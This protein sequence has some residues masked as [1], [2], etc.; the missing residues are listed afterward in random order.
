MSTTISNI[1]NFEFDK[2]L[3]PELLE[4]TYA[5]EGTEPTLILG[6]T[7]NWK[8]C[9]NPSDKTSIVEIVPPY[10]KKPS[11]IQPMIID[12]VDSNMKPVLIEF[13]DGS[14][15]IALKLFPNPDSLTISSSKIVNRYNTMTRW[16]EEHWGDDLDTINFSGSTYSFNAEY[17]ANVRTGL[18]SVFRNYS[19]SY[20]F[21]KELVSLYRTNG[22]LYQEPNGYAMT[23]SPTTEKELFEYS[24]TNRFLLQNPSFQNRH[25]RHGM[26]RERL[27]IRITFDYVTFIGYFESFDITEDTTSPFRLLYS[28]V[29]KAEKT[30]WT[31]G[32]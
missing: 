21:L 26:I 3:N 25:P 8:I 27:Y 30:I 9:Y 28:G 14:R 24:M 5:I 32:V 15:I 4:S 29:Y 17:K 20:K 1:S 2:Y 19:E 13:Q 12:M 11:N 7:K 23:K 6:P 16:V 31:V 18:T 22:Y 10:I